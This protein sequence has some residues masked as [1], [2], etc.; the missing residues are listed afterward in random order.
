MSYIIP[1]SKHERRIIHCVMVPTTG[2]AGSMWLAWALHHFYY[3]TLSL[4]EAG[5]CVKGLA[6]SHYDGGTTANEAAREIRRIKL[7]AILAAKLYMKKTH[8]I[9]VNR[10]FFS[11]VEPMRMALVHDNVEVSFLGLVGDGRVFVRS[12]ANKRAYVQG[13][14]FGWF[15]P[16]GHPNWESYSQIE[17]LSYHWVE[18]YRCMH[19]SGCVIH[20]IEDLTG[21]RR[22]WNFMAQSIGLPVI[23]SQVK[24]NR[25]A[26]E[27]LNHVPCNNYVTFSDLS[28]VD[29]EAFWSI[30][31]DTMKEL[32]Y[33][34]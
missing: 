9:E 13:R 8:Y 26:K 18:K 28:Q 4:H 17:K 10:N 6:F 25:I 2:R 5:Y 29:Q 33:H 1:P 27:R 22:Y 15:I 3:S 12:M 34:R 30:A 21:S 16:S 7:P 19:D 11:L 20:R 31:G 23:R 14:P 32:G 24:Y